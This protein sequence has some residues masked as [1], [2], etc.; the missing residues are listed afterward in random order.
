MKKL[1]DFYQEDKELLRSQLKAV[2]H[3]PQKVV[4]VVQAEIDKLTDIDGAYVG[5]LNQSQTRVALAF[6]VVLKLSLNNMLTVE[7]AP[8][9]SSKTDNDVTD[10]EH[11]KD[12]QQYITSLVTGVASGSA[13]GVS[14]IA[15]GIGTPAIPPLIAMTV[16]GTTFVSFLNNQLWD[17]HQENENQSENQSQIQPTLKVDI[18]RLL[19]QIEQQLAQIDRDVSNYDF[20]SPPPPPPKVQLTDLTD[21]IDFLHNFIGDAHY[22]LSELP[23]FTLSRYEQA[24]NLLRRNRIAVKFYDQNEQLPPDIEPEDAFEFENSIDPD[25]TEYINIRPALIKDKEVIRVGRVVKPSIASSESS[26]ESSEPS[27]ASSESSIEPSEP[28]I[29]SSESSIE[30]SEPSIASSESSIEE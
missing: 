20:S 2:A 30:P 19:L 25:A 16:L 23:Q 29:A 10:S 3:D 12:I 24:I 6:L 27:I 14:A 11:Q 18:D 17:K 21:V 8:Q 1:V 4:D 28:S 5:Q 15:L 26:I 9:P 22:E 7:Q 13:V